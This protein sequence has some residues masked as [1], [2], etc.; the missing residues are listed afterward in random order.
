MQWKLKGD[1]IA[2]R[3]S[4][5]S[6]EDKS[7][8]KCTEVERGVVQV[9]KSSPSEIYGTIQD[10]RTGR[11]FRLVRTDGHNWKLSYS[12]KSNNTDSKQ[13]GLLSKLASAPG[14]VLVKVKLDSNGKSLLHHYLTAKEWGYPGGKAEPDE[15][16]EDAAVRELKELTGYHIDKSK[17]KHDGIKNGHHQFSG[18]LADIS[19]I[20]P[21]FYENGNPR[22]LYWGDEPI[23]KSAN[24]KIIKQALFLSQLKI[25]AASRSRLPSGH[26]L[27]PNVA[28]SLDDVLERNSQIYG[29]RGYGGI[30]SIDDLLDPSNKHVTRL[31]TIPGKLPHSVGP[32]G[33]AVS[34][35][36]LHRVGQG[37]INTQ[38][39]DIYPTSF[40]QRWRTG[41]DPSNKPIYSL[42]HDEVLNQP[43][44]RSTG[45]GSGESSRGRF[46][47]MDK[48]HAPRVLGNQ[49]DQMH[50]IPGEQGRYYKN[51][52]PPSPLDLGG[53]GKGTWINKSINS[54]DRNGNVV[55]TSLL[56]QDD[57]RPNEVGL[58]FSKESLPSHLEGAQSLLAKH[59][60]S[61]QSPIVNKP[62][63]LASP[64]AAPPVVAP[65]APAAPVSILGK[66]KPTGRNA[67]RTA[68]A[69]ALSAGLGW[70]M[71]KAKDWWNSTPTPPPPATSQ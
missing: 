4:D 31:G 43:M 3:I 48:I 40:M 47:P 46:V 37:S 54:V 53:S 50:S 56:H 20:E 66:L 61:L 28:D 8:D 25:A 64:F 10:G 18:T 58:R 6:S 59:H 33:G 2:E 39:R 67:A 23:S 27:S 7:K 22:E 42:D 29:Q 68:V 17:L 38:G 60:N 5:L 32:G 16:M 70:G 11:S 52:L 24:L 71:N 14:K 41:Y 36:S 30:K 9:H 49:V 19:K 57:I 35:L 21:V 55:N 1:D 69:A 34:E 15:D 45:T 65:R 12:D 26:G 51:R 62:A 44:Y 63:T 13:A